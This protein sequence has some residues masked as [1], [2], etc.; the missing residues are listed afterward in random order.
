MTNKPYN[1][2]DEDIV[3]RMIRLG[4]F[5]HEIIDYT[6]FRILDLGSPDYKLYLPYLSRAS[7]DRLYDYLQKVY[8]EE[9]EILEVFLILERA[10]EELPFIGR[11]FKTFKTALRRYSTLGSA[12]KE[13]PEALSGL[14]YASLVPISILYPIGRSFD[15]LIIDPALPSLDD[16]W[17]VFNENVDLG[18]VDWDSFFA[19]SDSAFLSM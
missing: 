17:Q 11:L 3:D 10:K 2:N 18:I 19:E 14:A 12:V 4:E 8:L 5:C 9:T 7:K 13:S 1:V 6:L 16:L 15:E